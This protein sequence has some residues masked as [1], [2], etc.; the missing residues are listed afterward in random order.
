[1]SQDNL[2]QQSPSSLRIAVL[3][4]LASIV[5]L[6]IGAFISTEIHRQ[7]IQHLEKVIDLD[8]QI[9]EKSR[10]I[11]EVQAHTMGVSGDLLGRYAN[12]S[13]SPAELDREIAEIEDLR[14]TATSY[15]FQMRLLFA[16]QEA[17]FNDN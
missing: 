15:E 5:S 9:L 13:I 1:M 8:R 14:K 2:K 3:V 12:Q 4:I 17:L 6:G 11:I 10:K 16:Q 7:D